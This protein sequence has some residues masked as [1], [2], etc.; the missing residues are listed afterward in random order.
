MP[1][2]PTPTTPEPKLSSGQKLAGR[3]AETAAPEPP[4]PPVTPV[5][6]VT[7]PISSGSP[8]GSSEPE[9]P[10]EPILGNTPSGTPGGNDLPASNPWLDQIRE[11][12]FENVESEEDARE[13]LLLA[14]QQ[15]QQRLQTLVERVEKVA[16]LVRYGQQYMELQR[17]PR[18]QEHFGQKP[19][20]PTQQ[21]NQPTAPS[22]WWNPPQYDPAL[23]ARFR[24]AKV[25][26][27]SGQI[28]EDWD[29]KTPAAVRSSV[30]AYEQYI[31]EWKHKLVYNP[32]EAIGQAIRQ[33]FEAFYQERRSQEN[34]Q[35]QEL[36]TFDRFRQENAELLYER[37]PVSHRV[38]NQL[39]KSGR[40]IQRL[41]EE[42]EARGI[43]DPETLI[44][45]TMLRFERDFGRPAPA[46]PVQPAAPAPPTPAERNLEHLKKGAGLKRGEGGLPN[47][48]GSEPLPT[49]QR[50]P[51]NKNLTPGHR[52]IEQLKYDHVI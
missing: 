31:D 40:M 20:Q 1:L 39:S 34:Q 16:P 30:E 17:D 51:K 27:D 2:D 3:M 13:R 9:T 52:L 48:S 25:D 41:M 5:E 50:L 22:S 15:N 18:F 45:Y 4:T 23:V 42:G 36:S 11:L 49:D 29:E 19:A 46:A 47:R 6:P 10:P 38:T 43:S 28:I 7:P 26:P 21:P 12:G 24:V 37:D 32:K 35:H 8:A 33:E 14:Y 44:D